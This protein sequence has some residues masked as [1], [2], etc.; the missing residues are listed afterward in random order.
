MKSII[1]SDSQINSLYETSMFILPVVNN[2][3]KLLFDV[4]TKDKFISKFSPL[5]VDDEFF[6]QEE[7]MLHDTNDGFVNL[8]YKLCKPNF[9]N[10][11]NWQSA[12]EMT[13]EQSRYIL[14]CLNVNV[15]RIQDIETNANILRPL[16]VSWHTPKSYEGRCKNMRCAI[17]TFY[18]SYMTEIGYNKSYEDNDYLFL[19]E[20][21]IKGIK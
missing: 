4:D 19:F 11:H 14:K 7:F 2:N 20:F 1:L 10:S 13:K 6:I 18:E 15:I 5:Q 12:S 3:L 17:K 21:K 9:V 8:Y 16:G